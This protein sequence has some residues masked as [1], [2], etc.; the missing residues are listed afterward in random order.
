[1][2]KPLFRSRLRSKREGLWNFNEYAS[3]SG[4]LIYGIMILLLILFALGALFPVLWLFFS[5][6]KPESELNSV[7]YTFFP[8]DWQWNRIVDLWVRLDLGR[9]YLN[10]L[11]YVAGAVVCAVA[12]N[13]MLAY[14]ISRIR[15][16]GYKVIHYLIFL[17]YMIPGILN[18]LPIIKNLA[19]VG[20]FEI[21]GGYF[22]FLPLWLCFGANAYYYLLFKD[23][24]DKLPGEVLEAAKIDG[25]NELSIFFRIAMP[26]SRP[27]IGIVAVFA[28]TASYS[29]FLFPYLVLSD[30]RYKTLVVG[31]YNFGSNPS[32]YSLMSSDFLMLLVMSI[33][34]QIL[35]FLI[36][37]RQIMNANVN[38]GSKE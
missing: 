17:G 23:Y 30:D 31:I 27:I 8:Q 37:Q 32:A 21:E 10:T 28:M 11:I 18:I 1:M 6:L 35:I 16:F 26:L 15:P 2:R 7:H 33:V 14:A 5:A 38:S 24:F 29:D 20:F 36:F 3:A 9:Y 19:S 13:A 4:K 25:A 12:F 34:P 22:S